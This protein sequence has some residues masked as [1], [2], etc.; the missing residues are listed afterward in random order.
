MTK[1]Y[2]FTISWNGI[3]KLT[4]LY[5]SLMPALGNISYEWLIRDNGSKDNTVEIAKS[6]EGNIKVIPYK[7]N[8][9]N[10]AE[11]MNYLFA[12]AAPA[13]NDIVIL[14]NNDVIF[15]DTTSINNMLNIL[16]QDPSVGVVG[17]RLLYTNT[18]K[19]QHAGVVFDNQYK[20]PTHFRAG[21]TS[22]APAKRNREF[23]VVTGAVL[24]TRAEYYRKAFNKNKSGIN[25]IDEGFS[26]AF[27]DTDLCLCIKYNM[28]KKIVYCGDT[29][30]FH[31][32]SATLKKNP[33]NKLFMSHNIS[34]LFSKWKSRLVADKDIYTKNP[35]HNLYKF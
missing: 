7:D 13:D 30:I 20:T 11:G 25:G 21:Q 29:N 31:E 1:C 24:A 34:Y 8:R 12:T 27:D 32:E 10:F 28:D 17:A 2:I 4:K 26:W 35:K 22:D 16:N 6:W 19:L 3:D 15:N 5:Q 18:D 23:Q 9:Q 33:A 14:L